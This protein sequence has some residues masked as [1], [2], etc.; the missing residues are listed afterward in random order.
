MNEIE[1]CSAIRKRLKEGLKNLQLECESDAEAVKMPNVVDGF[2]P[3]KRDSNTDDF[4]FIVVRP[5]TGKTENHASTVA[6]VKLI[7]GAYNG[8]EKYD[9]HNDLILIISELRRII[10]ENKSIHYAVGQGSKALD[11]DV[12]AVFRLAYPFEWVIF[13]DQPEPFW[14]GEIITRWEIP[15]PQENPGDDL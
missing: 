8:S 3:P 1:L 15:A 12:G 7:I 2:L 11:A 4:P 13:E 6:T 9:G 10:F 5:V 14:E